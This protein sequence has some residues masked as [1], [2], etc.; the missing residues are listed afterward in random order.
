MSCAGPDLL[1]AHVPVH[2]KYILL[3]L[4]KNSMRATVEKHGVDRPPPIKIIVSDGESKRLTLTTNIHVMHYPAL[5]AA[6][7][8]DIVIKVSDEGGGI[9]RSNMKRIWSYLFTTAD[10]AILERMLGISI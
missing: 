8:E 7:N 2:V 9:K 10:P 3:E 6:G 1:F 4:L 5:M